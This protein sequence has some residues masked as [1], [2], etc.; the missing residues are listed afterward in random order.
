MLFIDLLSPNLNWDSEYEINKNQ[1]NKIFQYAFSIIMILLITY[2]VKLLNNTKLIIAYLIIIDIFLIILFTVNFVV[3]LNI[4]K[5][6]D[7]IDH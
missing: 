3:K 2:L 4:K 5:L 1:R 6:F 7:K